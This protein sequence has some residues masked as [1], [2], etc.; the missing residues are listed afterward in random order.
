MSGGANGAATSE[1][2]EEAA[3]P[4]APLATAVEVAGERGGGGGERP[5]VPRGLRVTA[6]PLAAGTESGA[7]E[8]TPPA[9]GTDA[10]AAGDDAARAMAWSA[11]EERDSS[12]P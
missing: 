10:A 9:E 4:A 6:S 11:V 5:E 2:V 8:A 3:L 1:D 7:E 12:S